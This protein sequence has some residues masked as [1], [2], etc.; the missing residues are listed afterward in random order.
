MLSALLLAGCVQQQ[1]VCNKPYIPFGNSCCLDKDNNRICDTDEAPKEEAPSRASGMV[2]LSHDIEGKA[3]PADEPAV[4]L[5]AAAKE[6]SSPATTVPLTPVGSLRVISSNLSPVYP[7]K[8]LIDGIDAGENI[9]GAFPLAGIAQGDHKLEIYLDSASYYENFSYLG[10]DVLVRF[11]P[12]VAVKGLV[13]NKAGDY[14]SDV[15]VYCDGAQVGRTDDA[16]SFEFAVMRGN[17]TIRLQGQGI[18]E[19]DQYEFTQAYNSLTF[20]LGRKYSIRV[21]VIDSASGDHVSDARVYLDE[22]A[23]DKTPEDGAISIRAVSEGT[24]VIEA[25]LDGVSVKRSVNVEKEDQAFELSLR[26]KKNNTLKVLDRLSGSPVSGARV[27]VDGENAGLTAPDGCLL[28]DSSYSGESVV[29]ISYLNYSA[30]STIDLSKDDGVV[31]VK[32]DTPL[33][34]TIEIKDSGTGKSVSGW[35]TNLDNSKIARAGTRT[36]ANG[37][38]KVRNVI[39]G[40]YVL[41]LHSPGSGVNAS[42]AGAVV[43]S[44]DADILSVSIDMPY[45]R[46]SGAMTCSEYG[47]YNK[48]GRCNVSV[49]NTPYEKSM[50]SVDAGV[51]LF[52]YTG[53]NS[54]GDE[55]YSLAGQHYASLPVISPGGVF[56]SVFDSL[57]EFEGDKKE[58]IIALILEDWEYSPQVERSVGGSALS[59][60]DLSGFVARIKEHCSEASAECSWVLEKK[61]AGALAYVN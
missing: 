43:L 47:V 50:P 59:A 32:F 11:D 41:R 29:E 9:N 40:S 6:D 36:D 22:G 4:E 60:S 54:T 3:A 31:T 15:Y 8:V 24:H 27:S 5:D 44:G 19:E 34:V 57:D 28:L 52:V 10:Q 56:S 2:V 13:L 45:P 61:I 48:M 26:I 1:T 49:R 42:Y 39:P 12:S 53:S 51:F 37:L 35:D 14:L 25:S 38:T 17:H 30:S 33:D 21:S 46:Y 55:I 7:T 58:V 20:S 23:Q 16:G 18:Y